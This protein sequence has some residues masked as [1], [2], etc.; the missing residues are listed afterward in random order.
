MALLAGLAACQPR[1]GP[2]E[3]A[4]VA[5]PPPTGHYAGGL[6]LPGRAEL[7]AALELRHPAPATTRPNC[8]SPATG[9]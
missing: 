5:L 9:P 3:E 4:A 6:Q 2:A 8:C 7:R 1:S